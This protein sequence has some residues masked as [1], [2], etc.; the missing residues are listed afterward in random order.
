MKAQTVA[1]TQ[2]G[3]QSKSVIVL[4][5]PIV[6]LSVGK[7]ALKLSETTIEVNA[8]ANHQTFQSENAITRPSPC[9][10]LVPSSLSPTPTSSSRRFSASRRSSGDNHF[11]VE[12]KS[13]RM[14]IE[15]IAKNTVK[16][17]S[18]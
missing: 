13:G 11:D 2:G 9:D 8:S 12:G 4:L 14:N 6:W 1:K 7:K 5:K 18:M 3:A 15:T 17:P 16:P 10:I